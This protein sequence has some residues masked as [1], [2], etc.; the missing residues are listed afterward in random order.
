MAIV[1]NCPLCNHPYKLKDEL[2]GKRATCKNPDCR[3]VIVIPAASGLSIAELGGIVPD[4]P[5]KND[6]PLPTNA[7]D[8]EAAALR[9]LS[10]TEQER[11]DKA[12]QNV[13]PVR[14]DYCAHEWTEPLEKAGKN[15]LCPNEECRQR[16]KVPMP[17]KGD[18]PHDWRSGANKPSLAKENFEKPADVVDAEAKVVSREA[19]KEG[20]GAEQELEP[21]SLKRRLFIASIIGTPILVLAIGI[22]F[23]VSWRKS[24]GEVHHFDK[25]VTEFAEG[26][27][28]LAPAE[29]PL[30]G[31]ILELAAGEYALNPRQQEKDKALAQSLQ[32]FSRARNELQSGA[33]K[34]E[35]RSAAGERYAVAGELALAI[36]GLGGTEEQV[37]DGARLR[38]VPEAAAG[39]TLRQK[40]VHTVH[41]ELLYT[42]NLLQQGGADFDT[43]S[44][45]TRR[46]ARDLIRRGEITLASNIPTFLFTP[47]EQ[48]EARAI[49][50]LELYRADPGSAE[51]RKTA[52]ELKALMAAGTV[53]PNPVPASAQALWAVLGIEKAP[54]LVPPLGGQLADSTRAAYVALRLLKPD[55]SSP[56]LELTQKPGGS[57]GGRLRALQLYAEWSA[58][59]GPAFDAAISSVGMNAKGKKETVPAVILVRLAQLAAA[60]G[61]VDQANQLADLIP[62]DGLKAWARGSAIQ[63]AMASDHKT[64]LDDAAFE[65]PADPKLL[66]AGHAWGRLWQARH[67]TRVDGA[68]AATKAIASWPKGT[69][70]PFGLAGIALG[71]HDR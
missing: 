47:A 39:R 17:K 31:G 7:A 29:A 59:P 30:F 26:R 10:E 14:C 62:D 22:W 5:G 32:H 58:E 25:A 24:E 1:F 69:I 45:L 37:N 68:S 6:T 70:H 20:G 40:T 46:L 36:L 53:R 63:F 55:Q 21:I 16:V 60:S 15:T 33:Q 56:A 50:A 8:I 18:A 51:A 38:W 66:R 11:E 57:L 28:E 64:K 43:R 65:V 9:A 3:K 61:R 54:V 41:E 4:G 35:R 44:I 71:Q 48:P 34:D 52:E 19:W 23:L 2:A 49:V 13:I 12:S 67:N 42:V 27:A